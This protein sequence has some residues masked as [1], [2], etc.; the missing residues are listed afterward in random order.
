MLGM[1]PLDKGIDIAGVIEHTLHGAL[2]LC[3]ALVV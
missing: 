3:Y 1:V 2:S